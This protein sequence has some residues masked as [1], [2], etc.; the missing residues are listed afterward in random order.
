MK[1]KHYT[2]FVS[3]FSFVSLLV[4]TFFVLGTTVNAQPYTAFDPVTDFPSGGVFGAAANTGPDQAG[5]IETGVKFRVSQGGV[6]NGIRYYK[7]NTNTGVHTV[8]LWSASGGSALATATG[9]AADPNGWVQINFAS[10]FTVAPGAVYIASV[11]MPTGR[12]AST[13]GYFS[14][15]LV[16]DGIE[17]LCDCDLASPGNG[18]FDYTSS[19]LTTPPASSFGGANYWIDISFT[20]F[21]PLP[22][23]LSDFNATTID[24]DVVLTWK[25]VSE[26]NNR[27]FEVQRSNNGSDWYAVN[28][29]AG[30][31]ESNVTRTY[32]YTDKSLAPGKYYYRLKQTDLDGKSTFS[33]TIGVLIS[34]K[35]IVS[36]FQNYPNPFNNSTT[37][38]FDLPKSQHARLS[39]LDM[40]GREVKVLSD[41]LA[42]AGSHLIKLDA[43]GLMRQSYLVRLQT[44]DGVL[45]Q[46]IMV[47]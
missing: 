43:A 1:L 16:N 36:L 28:F 45:T 10:S 27:G 35:G 22:V 31:N 34:G 13:G 23:R 5:G 17:L 25:T 9:S 20:P 19:P 32:S 41:K 39:L 40:S 24:K 37:I 8:H 11:Y 12:Y 38:R 47:Q 7:G 14:G 44:E 33:A 6:I 42:E 15:N 29:V 3:P 21:F 46:K 18:V 26:S 30:V 2:S 4:L